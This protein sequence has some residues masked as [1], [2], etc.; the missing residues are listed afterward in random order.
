MRRDDRGINIEETKDLL[1]QGE[2]GILS[3]VS[4]G[5]EPYGVPLSYCVID[6]SIY[7]HCATEGKK[8]EL[9][10]LNNKVSFCVVGKTEIL[11]NKFSTKYE[12]VIVNGII[13]NPPDKEKQIGLEGLVRKYSPDFIDEGLKYIEKTIDETKVL[14]MV[15]NNISGKARK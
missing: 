7:F 1:N 10:S 12:S 13:V 11:P 3:M 15:V 4:K 8:L 6:E 9:L 5:C 2:Y 14:K